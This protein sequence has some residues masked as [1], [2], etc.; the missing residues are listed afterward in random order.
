MQLIDQSEQRTISGIQC[1]FWGVASLLT[2]RKAGWIN[3]RLKAAQEDFKEASENHK[4][5]N[6]I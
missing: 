2:F 6:K 4:D 5:R 3:H 1:V